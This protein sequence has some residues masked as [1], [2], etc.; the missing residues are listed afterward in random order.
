[1]VRADG[2]VMRERVW[3]G[4]TVRVDGRVTWQS[5]TDIVMTHVFW[6]VTLC[7]WAE[8]MKDCSPSSSGSSSYTEDEGI[9]ILKHQVQ[10]HHYEKLDS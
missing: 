4:D 2:R 8:S 5:V 7:R 1:M 10:R 3:Y 6:E 9:V